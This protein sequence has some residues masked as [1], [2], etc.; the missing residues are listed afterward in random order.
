MSGLAPG[1]TWTT[2]H[3]CLHRTRPQ[4]T[5]NHMRHISTQDTHPH[6]TPN[7]H[8]PTGEWAGSRLRSGR[9]PSSWDPRRCP[10][11][12]VPC[13]LGPRSPGSPPAPSVPEQKPGPQPGSPRSLAVSG[14]CGSEIKAAQPSGKVTRRPAGRFLT[15]CS[16]SHRVLLKWLEVGT[17]GHLTFRAIAGSPR[18]SPAFWTKEESS[19]PAGR[20][21][22]A[23]P[24]PEPWAPPLALAG[25][26]DR[27]HGSKEGP[28][29]RQE[30][31][32]E[33]ARDGGYGRGGRTPGAGGSSAWSPIGCALADPG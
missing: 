8:G 32:G 30:G 31:L 23:T 20:E 11:V 6:G 13:R 12:W 14:F 19:L 25:Q 18:S 21:P 26:P 7:P 28:W 33:G 24:G 2:W 4:G 15:I 5:G 27:R 1:G 16:A 29:W 17:S 22:L 10:P 3:M 9:H